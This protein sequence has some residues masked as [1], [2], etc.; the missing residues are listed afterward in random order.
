[1]IYTVKQGDWLQGI[2]ERFGFASYKTIYDHPQ[3]AAFKQKRPDP[4][5]IYPGDQLFIPDKEEQSF[6]CATGQRHEFEVTILRSKLRLVL[7]AEAGYALAYRLLLGGEEHE[8]VSDGKAPI[9]HDVLTSVTSGA[10]FAWPSEMPA[11][12]RTLDNASHYLLA[13]GHLDPAGEISG[14]QQRLSNLGWE[15]TQSGELDDQTRDALRR[16]QKT[17]GLTVTGE[18]DDATRNKLVEEHDSV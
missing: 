12:E 15:P 13:L 5:V 16:Y 1:M 4:D 2:A 11:S 9:E 10:L 17:V 14:V 3:N 18:A 7:E 6:D 8:G